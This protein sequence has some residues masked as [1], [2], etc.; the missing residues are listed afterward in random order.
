MAHPKQSLGNP[1]KTRIHKT[2]FR[3]HALEIREN[4]L[5]LPPYHGKISEPQQQNG[6]ISVGTPHKI[7]PGA[8]P[9]LA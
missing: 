6:E 1:K 7:P 5:R 2:K 4:V 8:R 9:T 3:E